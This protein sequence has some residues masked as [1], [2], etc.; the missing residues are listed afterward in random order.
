MA[1]FLL[2]SIHFNP[3]YFCFGKMYCLK[4]TNMYNN[5]AP[6]KSLPFLH[7]PMQLAKYSLSIGL[8][9]VSTLSV[10]NNVSLSTQRI[11]LDQETPNANFVIR[12]RDN[13]SQE[14]SLGLTYFQFDE[15]G[16]MLP[17]DGVTPPNAAENIARYSP[18]RFNIEPNSK[19]TVRFTLRRKRDIP[20][21][22]HRSYITV[23]CKN[24]ITSD[25]VK[26]DDG[27]ASISIRPQLQHNIPLIVR[28]KPLTATLQFS[29]VILDNNRLS[30]N[31][32]RQGPRSVYG[33]VKLVDLSS[34]KTVSE[35]GNFAIYH[36]TKLKSLHMAVPK[37]LSLNSLKLEFNES[38]QEG[39]TFAMWQ[40][41]PSNY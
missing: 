14:C 2:L 3:K 6:T 24:I 26:V 19:Q 38:K 1:R 34:G 35:S 7:K 39:G 20:A 41:S 32:H 31:L 15:H 33:K 16:S 30:F 23:S 17:Y 25:S 22:E 13:A 37:G 11:Y 36:E 8:M 9:F 21:I 5:C 12:N 40:A 18:K 10:A 29:D 27:L 28:P 4:E